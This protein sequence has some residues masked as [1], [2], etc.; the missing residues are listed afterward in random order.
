[1]KEYLNIQNAKKI[2]NVEEL[3]MPCFQALRELGD[4]AT[5]TEIYSKVVEILKLSDDILAVMHTENGSQTRVEYNLAWAR[6]NLKKYGAIDNPTR[7]VWEIVHEFKKKNITKE[8]VLSKLQGGYGKEQIAQQKNNEIRG[9]NM[10]DDIPEEDKPWYKELSQVLSQ[11]NPYS[12][13][14]FTQFILRTM[15]LES[16][17]VTKKSGDGGVDGYGVLKLNGIISFN[18]AFQCKRYKGAVGA[19]SIRD[20]RGSIT[21]DI[22]K[23]LMIT[24]GTFTEDAK[25]EASCTGKI[26]IDLI[27]G[28]FL[29]NKIIELNIGV[30]EAK[31]Y[32]VDKDFFLNY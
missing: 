3:I 22:E 19:S 2:P 15:G 10:M 21:A 14:R 4:S 25:K 1:M 16:V 32:I 7:G 17:V 13:E 24:T 27:D 20:F 12:F 11:M 5:S 30:K 8:E 18:M 28:D 26:K 29:I 23:A 31:T 9:Y 6:T